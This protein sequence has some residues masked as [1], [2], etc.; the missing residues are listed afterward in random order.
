MGIESG[1]GWEGSSWT[2]VVCSPHIT[3]RH[4]TWMFPYA[5]STQS[6]LCPGSHYS[7]QPWD[8]L[9]PTCLVSAPAQ[10]LTQRTSPPGSI[11]FPS[12]ENEHWYSEFLCSVPSLLQLDTCTCHL[13]VACVFISSPVLAVGSLSAGTRYGWHLV[14]GSTQQC[15][16]H[17]RCSI[18][19]N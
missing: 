14:P 4:W 10:G 6:C 17:S 12:I 8:S 9:G 15:L 11:L 2:R 13:I 1:L 16:V 3:H 7:G 18:N 19:S 5:I